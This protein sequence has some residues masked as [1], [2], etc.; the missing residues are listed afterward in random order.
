MLD[1]NGKQLLEILGKNPTGP[2]ILT[3][4]D[5]PKALAAIEAA[6]LQEAKKN[7]TKEAPQ[8]EE[9]D[10]GEETERIG[11]RTRT[12]PFIEMIHR[13]MQARVDVVWGI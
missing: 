2:G 7:E 6:I 11:L 5:M 3:C 12:R 9:F 8:D 1:V 4:E 13:C 10:K